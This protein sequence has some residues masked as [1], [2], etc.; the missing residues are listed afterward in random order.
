M[1][2][3]KPDLWEVVRISKDGE[4]IDKVY[5]SWRGGYITPDEWRLSSGI[6][7]VVENDS[8]YQ[9]HNHS[10][11]IYLCPKQARGTTLFT[12]AILEQLKE[13]MEENGGWMELIGIELLVK[14][15]HGKS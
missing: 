2:T 7:Q 5:A 9:I 6:T 1:S 4:H 14:D 10:G 13:G 3:Y 12:Q 8:H 11:S 15:D